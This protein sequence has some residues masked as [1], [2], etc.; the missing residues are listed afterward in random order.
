LVVQG[1]A[2]F[3]S[4]KCHECHGDNGEGTK[5]GPKLAGEA[6]RW[7]SD[8]ILLFLIEPSAKALKAKMPSLP[9][10]SADLDPLVAFVQSLR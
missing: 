2:L 7:A 5:D 1:R 6:S 4:Q 3:L 10:D 9:A 8:R